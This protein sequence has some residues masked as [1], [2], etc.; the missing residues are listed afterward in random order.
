MKVYRIARK[1]FISD[2]SGEGARIYGGRWNKKGSGVL[3]TSESRSLATVEYLVH[4]SWAVLPPDLCIAEIDIPDAPGYHT[5]DIA[6][7]PRNWMS[8]P[9]PPELQEIGEAWKKAGKELLLRVPSVVVKNEW[10]CLVNPG[11]PSFGRIYIS[12]IDEY[13]LDPRLAK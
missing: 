1:Q 5:I 8:Y 7:L 3:Y 11:H 12:S 4:L 9:A 10:N 2:L 6:G 13:F